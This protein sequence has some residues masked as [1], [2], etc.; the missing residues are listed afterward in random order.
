MGRIA[1]REFTYHSDLDLIFL[2]SGAPDHMSATARVGQRMI[3]YLSTMTGAGVAY[4]VD[5]RLRPSGHQGML[6]TSF[7]GFERYQL[8]RAET[9][10]HMALLRSRA[11]AGRTDLAQRTLDRVTRVLLKRSSDPWKYIADL[12]SR[13]ERERAPNARSAI[14]LK[15]GYGG[16]MDVDFL[17]KGALLERRCE[18]L[19]TLPSVPAMLRCVARGRA[20]EQLLDDYAFLRLVESRARWL[21]G[22]GVEEVSASDEKASLVAELIDLELDAAGLRA[23]LAESRD[24]IRSGFDAVVE[25]SSIAALED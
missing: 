19:P 6:V 20:I 2:D 1:G 15:T 24:R 23:K 16:L 21:A 25:R 8:E 7:D 17:A 4:A 3:S 14:P 12:R 9:W 13:V 5:T 11:I 10:E 18:R 22:R